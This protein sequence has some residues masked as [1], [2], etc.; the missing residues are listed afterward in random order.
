MRAAVS[1]RIGVVDC[2]FE[3]PGAPDALIELAAGQRSGASSDLARRRLDKKRR[4]EEVQDVRPG[5]WY[6]R[7]F[8]SVVRSF[9]PDVA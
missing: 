7:R 1:G 9:R 5:A 4:A 2:L 3:G 6:D 8:S